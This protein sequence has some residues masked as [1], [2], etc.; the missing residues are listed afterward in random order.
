[1]RSSLLHQEPGSAAG[2][3]RNF[4]VSKENVPSAR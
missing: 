3:E 2:A 1:M 4:T